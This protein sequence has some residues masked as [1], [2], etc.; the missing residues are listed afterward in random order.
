MRLD[1]KMAGAAEPCRVCGEWTDRFA[2]IDDTYRQ[3]LCD[4][5]RTAEWMADAYRAYGGA[6]KVWSSW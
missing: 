6:G 4:E 1:G 2:T 5:H 3:P